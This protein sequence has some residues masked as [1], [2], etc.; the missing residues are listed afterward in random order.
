MYLITCLL[1]FIAAATKAQDPVRYVKP[2]AS[3]TGDASSWANASGDLQATINNAPDDAV[4]WIAA[5][6]YKPTAGTDKNATF[7][8]VRG[9]SLFGGFAGNEA[10]PSDRNFAANHTIL[11]GD[12]GSSQVIADNSYHVV[13]ANPG[14]GHECYVDGLT[15]TNGYASGNS[16][17][18]YNASG[19]GMVIIDANDHVTVSSCFFINNYANAYGGAVVMRAQSDFCD[20]RFQFCVFY[21]NQAHLRGGA[22]FFINDGHYHVNDED[23]GNEIDYYYCSFVGNYG[24]QRGGALAGYDVLSTIK[25]S[26]FW[27]NTSDAG[28][29]DV[30]GLDDFFTNFSNSDVKTFTPPGTNNK[31]QDPN[32]SDGSNPA[33]ADGIWGTNDDGLRPACHSP[34][35][36]TNQGASADITGIGQPSGNVSVAG[37]YTIVIHS[38]SINITTP[39]TYFCN[40]TV[41]QTYT[42]TIA[43]AGIGASYQWKK[44]GVNVGSNSSTYYDGAVANNDAIS[45]TL[46][47]AVCNLATTIVS[48][49]ITISAVNCVA[50]KTRLYVNAQATGDK[51]GSSWAN[52]MTDLQSAINIV[53]HYGGEVWVKGDQ[54]YKPSGMAYLRELDEANYDPAVHSFSLSSGVGVYGGF[55][56][57]ET[58]LSQRNISAHPTVL[59]GQVDWDTSTDNNSPH[60][61]LS[62]GNDST[63]VLD[64]FYIEGGNALYLGGVSV[65]PNRIANYYGGGLYAVN[66]AATIKNCVLEKNF[67]VEGGGAVYLANS[68]MHLEK[69][70]FYKN[71]T[72]LLGG[73]IAA[74]NSA[75][76]LANCIFDVDSAGTVGEY[77][78][79]WA[80]GGAIYQ[81]QSHSTIVNCTITNCYS[82]S[83]ATGI[84]NEDDSFSIKNTIIYNN[85]GAAPK[86]ISSNYDYPGVSYSDIEGGV[87][88][89]IDGGHNKTGSPAF[90]NAGNAIGAD[91]KW[92]TGDDGLM[93]LCT[94]A[95][96]NTGTAN[97]APAK[98]IA[99]TLR[100]NGGGV[101]MGAF[102]RPVQPY[103]SISYNPSSPI[104]ENTTVTFTAYGMPGNPAFSWGA[105]AFVW[106]INDSVQAG[107]S[108]ATFTKK[109]FSNADVVKCTYIPGSGNCPVVPSAVTSAVINL[110][111]VPATD[112]AITTAKTTICSITQ[113]NFTATPANGGAKPSYQWTINGVKA[114]VDSSVF[115][116]NNW[117]NNDT[118]S[119]IMTS[120]AA[121]ATPAFAASNK[122]VITVDKPG[123]LYVNAAATGQNNGTSW[124]DA[125]T[126]LQGALGY[127]CING[128]T[129]IWVAKGVYK[130]TQNL[131]NNS[132]GPLDPTN[133]FLLPAANIY[134][135]FAGTETTLGQRNPS[136]NLTILSGDLGSDDIND[137]GNN[138]NEAAFHITGTNAL[139]V[140][141][142]NGSPAPMGLDGFVIT[143]GQANGNTAYLGDGN[144]NKIGGGAYIA[145][146]GSN[147]TITRCLFTGNQASFYGAGLYTANTTGSTVTNC[148]FTGNTAYYGGAGISGY[149]STVN[150]TNTIFT[151]N[152]AYGVG[153]AL[154]NISSKPNI[155]N[156][157]F[158]NNSA[159]TSGGAIANYLNSNA[160][161]GNCIIWG[162]Q[163]G[164]AQGIYN[165]SST[166]FVTYTIVQGG[167]PGTGNKN[168]DPQFTNTGNL[169]GNDNIWG[170]ADDGLIINCASPAKD[171][172]NAAG[173]TRTDIT[174][175]PR[176]QVAGF[177]MGAYEVSTLSVTPAVSVS[178][179]QTNICNGSSVTFTATPVNG[180]AA[181]A[182]QW[183]KNNIN[184]GTNTAAYNDAALVN[185]DVISC[186]M[187]S[188]SSCASPVTATSNS[189]T[190]AVNPNLTPAV[191][192][193]ASQT[194]IC[195]GALVTFTAAPANGGTP[196]YQ[197]LKNGSNVGTNSATYASNT[198]ANNDIISCVMTGNATCATAP[199]AT[200]NNIVMSNT[201]VV[202]PS[203]SI[204]STFASVC[205][206][207]PVTF[208]A[209]P[210]NGGAPGYQWL[211]NGNNVGNNSPTY[212][213]ADF[214]SSDA[215]SVVMTSTAACASSPTATSN[216]IQVFV[217]SYP[218]GIVFVNANAHGAGNG[219]SW[220]DAYTNLQA[221]LNGSSACILPIWIAKGTYYPSSYAYGAGSTPRDYAFGLKDGVN[222]YGGFAGN[223]TLLSQ[224][225][226]AANPTILSGDIGVLNDNSDN[227]YHV[228]VAPGTNNAVLDGFIIKDGNANGTGTVDVLGHT[229]YQNGGGAIFASSSSVAISNCVIKS[230][231]AA[232]YGAGAYLD[233]GG[234]TI[235]NVVFET[236]T[237]LNGGGLFAYNSAYRAANCIF[238][239]NM[240]AAK[241]GGLYELF[242]NEKVTNSTF[243]NNSAVTDGGGI[244]HDNSGGTFTNC[245]V[246]ANT[247]GGTQ[248]IKGNTYG[249][250]VNYSIVQ[251]GF[252]GNGN[253]G[254]D[255][256]FINTASPAGAD[257]IWGTADDGLLIGC[258]S[259]AKDAGDITGAPAKDITG[260][261]RPLGNGFDIG[262]YESTSNFPGGV[263]YVDANAAGSNTGASWADAYTNLQAAINTASGCGLP[264][265]VKAG[266]YKPTTGTDRTVAF[267]LPANVPLY[268]GFAGIETSLEQRN[269]K[270]NVTILS[271][272]IGDAGVNTDNSYTI[273]T[274]AGAQYTSIDGF[275]IS[276]AYS[277]STN[278]GGIYYSGT[279][280]SG[281]L[282]IANCN[283]I[284]NTALQG[285]S[286]YSNG[287]SSAFTNLD[288]QNCIFQGN[289]SYGNGAGIYN[290]GNGG[291]ANLSITNSI[292]TNNNCLFVGA[293]LF[294]YGAGANA[295]I[296]N[297]TFNKDTGFGATNGSVL[298]NQN[299]A[300]LT[301]TNSIIWNNARTI[302]Y[303]AN[304][305]LT[306]SYCNIQGG[307]AGTGNITADPQFAN[308]DNAIGADNMWGTGDDGLHLLAGSPAIDAGINTAIPALVNTDIK[309]AARI[310]G[311][312]VDMGAYEQLGN[313]VWTGAVDN[314]WNNTG[315]WNNNTVP[316]ATDDIIIPAA[317]A[318]QPVVSTTATAHGITLG[319]TLT[320]ASAGTLSITGD[321]TNSGTFNASAGNI[322]FN[323]AA[324]QTIAGAITVKNLTVN[325]ANGVTLF[326]GITK[327]YGTYTPTAGVLTSNGHLVLASTASGT[328]N[329]ANSGSNSN[330]VT[331]TVT[332][333]RYIPAKRAWRILTAPLSQTGTIY[334]NWQN[335]GVKDDTS[336][337]EIFRPGGGNG[338]TTAGVAASIRSYDATQNKWVDL[339]NTNATSIGNNN[340]SA[341]NDGFVV[342]VT[343]P[344]GATSTI[345]GTPQATTLR[346]TGLLQ[347]GTQVFS[348]TAPAGNF[349]LF[350]NPYA[351]PIDFTTIG[352]N[353]IHNT[354]WLWDANNAGLNG[355]GG[356]IMYSYDYTTGTYDK[357]GVG[358][359][360]NP[361]VQSGQ[362]FFVQA[363][364]SSATAGVTIQESDKAGSSNS[365]NGVFFAPTGNTSQQLRITLN[366]ATEPLDNILLKFGQGYKTDQTDDGEKLFN[367][368]ENISIKTGNKY[369]GI[370]RMPLPAEGDT[371]HLYM[372]A[373]KAKAGYSLTIQP[374]NIDAKLKAYLVDKY[375]NTQTA[376]NLAQTSE[377]A[378][379]TTADK[380]SYAIDRY[381]I[382]FAQAGVLASNKTT[383][384]A[385]L[386]DK[387]VD[388]SWSTA[389]E[390]GIQHYQVERSADGQVF[391]Q[392]NSNVQPRNTGH[393]E[394]YTVTDETPQTGNNYYRIKIINNN[395][396][397]TYSNT[398]VVK[399]DRGKSAISIYP[400]PVVRKQQLHITLQNMQAG[401]YTMMLYTTEGKQVVQRLLQYDGQTA[402]QTINLPL[403]LAAGSYRLV[404]LDAKG[405]EWKQQVVVQ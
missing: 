298:R 400:N 52:A 379:T 61:V 73:G 317:P 371:I 341:A 319:G 46:T 262:A 355:L 386:K 359:G 264:V 53:S 354:V 60:V 206:G 330:Y 321:V 132:S 224:R 196:A 147:L 303:E 336:G 376:I 377:V 88:A 173:A 9:I 310:Q 225:N 33:G 240:A 236:N 329:V 156:C 273:L 369:Y 347:T 36:L 244:Y 42:A 312:T 313:F 193:T 381:V 283:F 288:I 79:D 211:K 178:A 62:V 357:A 323:G 243:Y 95:A 148:V 229:F 43:D 231:N 270:A 293:A 340:A 8:L 35:I 63:A 311:S 171:A 368:N 367:Y 136:V 128:V 252:S 15:I 202:T 327:V 146:A 127:P 84:C 344:F 71:T 333:E 352:K 269:I 257:G 217:S 281:K 213:A 56:G 103:V 68:P 165:N 261:A 138:I 284:N 276:G 305:T 158:Y 39:Q 274:V 155:F 100:P 59:S 48:N 190:M 67:S 197:W 17:I 115:T 200:S 350:G 180:G 78:F 343:G 26:I 265:W 93:I 297:S 375:L 6:T 235:T 34:V 90:K 300:T 14:T 119:V 405:N 152:T 378:I 195:N 170:T 64:G 403:S 337:A 278:G 102:E 44:N 111:P 16:D 230:N 204:T 358:A 94:S 271:G 360:T 106:A 55:A 234:P 390:Q 348:K 140:V 302:S 238:Y 183:L 388:I 86:A 1:L 144:G 227:C 247:G 290:N 314:E 272:D 285:A 125:F 162:N 80:K 159:I 179:S 96:Y 209:T 392:L 50:S 203:V 32:F 166:P 363:D 121:C 157:T 237:A 83:V 296:Y 207:T 397:V 226:I 255:P 304:T 176:P 370:E 396:T 201:P 279:N 216:S 395:A 401:K 342:F 287:S 373:L 107:A 135:G 256:L 13:T 47:P 191:A 81:S 275:T 57:N 23:G 30:S 134:G 66:S 114:G 142:V 389:G 233:F 267:S 222:M 109:G 192:I 338:F 120:N 28:Y 181:P 5:G 307:V 38:S 215:V 346:A 188:N 45:C 133:T 177:D 82:I 184:A 356:Y 141:T 20:P 175:L 25:A 112:V 51:S 316:T 345:T 374:Q 282:I 253:T 334:T 154:Y 232:N 361:V 246:Y 291:T 286:I 208:T 387:A 187:T 250:F 7:N 164:G 335:G 22:T 315:N 199:T 198:V 221:A 254:D 182:Y 372:Y 245:I 391:S 113:A 299:F 74:F 223:E 393:T 151:G 105:D 294:N 362:A 40:P 130:P 110:T 295:A 21:N 399:I 258:A 185:G 308:S 353:N 97:G 27:N 172:G 49:T 122:I 349:V 306:V 118:V 239:N 331:G 326:S 289:Y 37:A 65:G 219:T 365:N 394:S 249:P 77:A 87:D 104:C 402:T 248:G 205:G 76:Y 322:I 169:A 168:L 266:T 124:V 3:G 212:S 75:F 263:V 398:V 85:S 92:G 143:G 91:G 4:I 24:G 18:D 11:S 251:G 277:N 153:G 324:T 149:F 351:S 380:G 260:T 383:V 116:N 54:T 108:S 242:A 72:D 280:T 98:D 268:G 131:N 301:V 366:K 99:D 150:I 70:I 292:F 332:V 160:V 145:G 31:S 129:E 339:T 259:P 384:S 228:V 174:G 404:L 167:Y 214:N 19:G 325:N 189:I 328:A 186:V 101:D 241:G 69:N 41:P 2:V 385:T 139:H 218:Q 89:A 123:R 194:N 163:G 382:T 309:G 318:N 364:G 161:I 58:A 220:A 126:S 137:D 29:D 10:N 320:V 12:I 210:V 117:N